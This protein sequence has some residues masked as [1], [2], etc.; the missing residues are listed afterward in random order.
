M[1]MRVGEK[2]LERGEG[3]GKEIRGNKGG[4]REGKRKRMFMRERE[5]GRRMLEDGK[6]CGKRKGEKKELRKSGGMQ[7][8]RKITKGR[9]REG[10]EKVGRREGERKEGR[11]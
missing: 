3:R 5:G 10:K 6:E 4:G 11:R 7:G 8:K 1:L 2:T 9:D